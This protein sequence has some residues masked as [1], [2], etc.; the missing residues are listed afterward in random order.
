M[1]QLVEVAMHRPSLDLVVM[2]PE[3]A[4]EPV[5]A[6]GME[7]DL[8]EDTEEVVIVQEDMEEEPVVEVEVE[9]VWVLQK[10]SPLKRAS[11]STNIIIII[12]DGDEDDR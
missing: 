9:V 11:A 4:M 12:M 5:V 2:P 1:E 8:E 7:V 10:R 6:E 3:E